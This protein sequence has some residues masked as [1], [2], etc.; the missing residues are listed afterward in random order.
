MRHG[1]VPIWITTCF[2]SSSFRSYLWGMETTLRGIGKMSTRWFRSYLWGM[3]TKPQIIIRRKI[4]YSDPTYEAWKLDSAN[5]VC[6]NHYDSDPTYEAWKPPYLRG[7]WVWWWIPI[8][9]MR[10]G[11]FS[12]LF[13]TNCY[14]GFRSYLWG[15]E[16]GSGPLRNY[17]GFSFRSYLWG[18]ETS[19]NISWWSLS[20][21]FRSYLWGME[22]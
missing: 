19:W 21:K 10:H 6:V 8:L 22:T 7:N 17:I 5:S 3:E 4:P 16:T 13:E 11:N 9:P 14:I 12:W 20:R 15:M 2:G 1:N 18:M